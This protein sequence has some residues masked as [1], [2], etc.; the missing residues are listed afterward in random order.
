MN[1]KIDKPIN[2]RSLA[3]FFAVQMLFAYKEGENI[4]DLYEIVKDSYIKSELSFVENYVNLEILRKN[5]IDNVTTEEVA[6][7]DETYI[8]DLIIFIK[9]KYEKINDYEKIVDLQC[10]QNAFINK[11]GYDR[12]FIKKTNL[13]TQ[14]LMDIV[15]DFFIEKNVNK[16]VNLSFLKEILFGVSDNLQE[17][18]KIISENL[19]KNKTDRLSIAIIRLAIYELKYTTTD[20]KI[21]I[22][23][24]VDIAGEFFELGKKINFINAILN[25]IH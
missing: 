1:D 18:D 4:S 11:I 6:I 9:D 3:R 8:N 19:D 21:I 12:I 10:L 7:K 22:N 23:E 5:L 14:T 15:L 2:K 25:N 13:N 24:Y 16:N 17:I 20:K